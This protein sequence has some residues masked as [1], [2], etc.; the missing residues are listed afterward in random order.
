MSAASCDRKILLDAR[1][2]FRTGAIDLAQLRRV[3]DDAIR[4][5]VKFQEE[6][7]L[8]GITD[9]EYRRTYFHIDFLTQLGGVTT[10]G[11]IHVAST[12]PRAR[13]ISNRP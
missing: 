7:G 2:Q 11:G 8:R 1:E 12:V 5:I 4:G 10:K 3:E 9:G 6:L 13:S